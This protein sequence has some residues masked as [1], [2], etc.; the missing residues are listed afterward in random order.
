MTALRPFVGSCNT[1][2]T[3]SQDLPRPAMG[4]GSVRT[5]G[6]ARSRFAAGGLATG[7]TLLATTRSVA[8]DNGASE[9]AEGMAEI[10]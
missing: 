1:P 6:Q 2:P 4:A 9:K 3:R 8:L 7:A 10:S 5:Q